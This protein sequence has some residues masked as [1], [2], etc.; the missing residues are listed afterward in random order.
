MSDSI[1]D[2]VSLLGFDN[3]QDLLKTLEDNLYILNHDKKEIMEQSNSKENLMKLNEINEL[4]K[5]TESAKNHLK[6]LMEE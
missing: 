6:H 5:I 1:K 4:I 3:E 2:I